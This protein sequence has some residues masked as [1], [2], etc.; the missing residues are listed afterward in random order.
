VLLS[1]YGGLRLS[2]WRASRRRDVTEADGRYLVTVK[3]Q[4]Q[5]VD[6]AWVIGKPKS[7]EGERVVAL[8]SWATGDVSAHLVAY[9]GPSPGDLLFAPLGRSE[10]IHDSAFRDV[11]NPARAAAGLRMAER[12]AGGNVTGWVNVAREHD[13]RAFAGT[14]HAQSGAT[15]RETMAFLGHSTTQAAMAY[16]HASADRLREIADRM[17]APKPL[18]PTTIVDG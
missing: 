13:L 6:G 15:L 18:T 3:R 11:W 10:F 2:E 8:P 9:V 12:D 16:Q 1:A 5:F 4:A 7:A 17:P 14:L